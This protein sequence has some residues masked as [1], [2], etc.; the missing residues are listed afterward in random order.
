[1]LEE[2]RLVKLTNFYSLNDIIDLI[3][4][5][6]D[7]YVGIDAPLKVENESGNREIEVEFLKDYA[8]KKLGVYPVN[9][10]L[11]LKYSE[12]IAGE[13]IA[14]N[15]KQKLGEK[16]FEVYPH[17]TI[18]NCFHGSVLPYKRKKGRSVDFIRSQ[19]LLLQKYLTNV[20]D[21]DFALDTERLKGGKLKEYEDRLDA[22]VCAYT[23]FHC[24]F[25]PHATY[26]GIFKVP[27]TVFE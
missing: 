3:N 1:V 23:M 12:T 2:N 15:V 21:G 9:R 26:G 27:Y 13:V 24:Q 25:N 18:M 19:L 20:I 11:L 8:Y 17:V 5:Y 10:N 6:P 7:A 14:S 16:L 4:N 22:L